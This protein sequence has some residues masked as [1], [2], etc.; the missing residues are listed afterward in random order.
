MPGQTTLNEDHDR[1]CALD[2]KPLAGRSWASTGLLPR[3]MSQPRERLE[4]QGSARAGRRP[5]P[6]PPAGCAA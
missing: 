5:T 3:F 1:R 4:L 6:A 2:G